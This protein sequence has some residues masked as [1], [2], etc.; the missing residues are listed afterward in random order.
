MD[1]I[2]TAAYT[3]QFHSIWWFQFT[4]GRVSTHWSAAVA[5]YRWSHPETADPTIREMWLHRNSIVHGATVEENAAR[6]IT[7]LHNQRRH[8]CHQFHENPQYVLSR[9]HHLIA[10]RTLEQRLRQSYD[11]LVCWLCSVEEAR[12]Y[13]EYHTQRLQEEAAPFFLGSITSSSTYVP[14]S[15]S[16]TST[17]LTYTSTFSSTSDMLSMDLNSS[18][19]SL[20]SSSTNDSLFDNPFLKDPSKSFGIKS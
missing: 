18:H 17:T 10:N 7:D 16:T 12:H 8:H 3:E 11:Y 15:S 6:I 14:S 4:L 20:S 19:S 9:H 13:L 5:L 2:L 1:M